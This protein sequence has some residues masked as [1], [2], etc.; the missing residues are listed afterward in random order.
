MSNTPPTNLT[1]Q[2]LLDSNEGI[3]LYSTDCSYD[4]NSVVLAHHLKYIQH[5][6]FR[7][8]VISNEHTPELW[9]EAK[10][11]YSSVNE[12]CKIRQRYTNDITF[13]NGSTIEFNCFGDKCNWAGHQL[14]SVV[15][16]DLT[17]FKEDQM[18]YLFSRLLT[19]VPIKTNLLATV[20]T[21]LEGWVLKYLDWYLYPDGEVNPSRNGQVRY[22]VRVGGEIIWGGSEQELLD[23]YPEHQPLSFR[24]IAS[25]TQK[26]VAESTREVI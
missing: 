7:G 26:D 8:A 4:R 18:W 2:T 24:F 1:Q 17:N 16:E 13:Q 6:E 10:S 23:S 19:K 20:G 3:V 11:L 22:L 25:N 21:D 14:G 9:A 5:P 12:F 15:L